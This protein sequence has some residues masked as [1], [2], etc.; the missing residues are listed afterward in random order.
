MKYPALLDLD[1]DAAIARIASGTLTKVLA[2]E[3]GV[4]KPT[5]RDHLVRH[6]DYP[7]AIKA[8]AES[9][10]EQA[11][12]ECLSAELAAETAVIARARLRLDAAHKWAAARDP[13][14]WSGKPDQSTQGLTVNV[15]QFIVSNEQSSPV[16]EPIEHSPDGSPVAPTLV[17]SGGK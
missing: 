9:L 6:P 10:V 13:G 3:L 4:P 16:R 8:Q 12:S 7:Q 2:A 17:D 5:L 14:T 11:T 15:V 1:L